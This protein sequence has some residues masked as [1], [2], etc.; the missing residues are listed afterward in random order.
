MFGF[1]N[2]TRE[3]Y[4]T[5]CERKSGVIINVI[6]SAGERPSAADSLGVPVLRYRYYGMIISGAFAGLGGAVMVLFANRYQEN[7]VGGRGFLG[8]GDYD[9]G[10][11]THLRV[12]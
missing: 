3:I 2:L 10:V 7:Q 4:R 12:P 11:V 1:V 8:F 9:A 5:M 6:G